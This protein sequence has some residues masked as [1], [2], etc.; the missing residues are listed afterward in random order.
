MSGKGCE[1]FSW[2]ARSALNKAVSDITLN[3]G[4]GVV[5]VSKQLTTQHNPQIDAYRNCGNC[6]T[7]FNYH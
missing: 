4:I 7:H 2:S 3:V 6:G 1:N 5:S